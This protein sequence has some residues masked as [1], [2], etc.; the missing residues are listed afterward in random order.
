MQRFTHSTPPVRRD[1]APRWSLLG[2]QNPPVRDW[3]GLRVWVIGASSGIGEATALALAA[4]GAQVM[5]SARSQA[6]LQQLDFMAARAVLAHL[7]HTY[8]P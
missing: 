4:R 8:A 3:R 7:Q 1:S 5:V 6:A 2:P